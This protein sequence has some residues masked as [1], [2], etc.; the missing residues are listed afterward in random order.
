MKPIRLADAANEALQAIKDSER[1]DSRIWWA[2]HMAFAELLKVGQIVTP[3]DEALAAM[4]EE[5]CLD[6]SGRCYGCG[7]P[8]GDIFDWTDHTGTCPIVEARRK[9]EALDANE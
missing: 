6:Y 4:L 7:T 2:G 9:V 3:A 5:D 8:C 1:E